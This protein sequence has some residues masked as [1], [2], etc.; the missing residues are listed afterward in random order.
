MRRAS[1]ATG[2]VTAL[3]CL[4]RRQRGL[5]SRHCRQATP[6]LAASTLQAGRIAGVRRACVWLWRDAGL[7]AR[8]ACLKRAACMAL[9][10]SRHDA[11]RRPGCA[12]MGTGGQ[13][14]AGRTI[15]AADTPVEVAGGHA[16]VAISAGGQHTCAIEALPSGKAFCWGVSQR[17]GAGWPGWAGWWVFVCLCVYLSCCCCSWWTP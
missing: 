7:C 8:D 6:T 2:G 17:S 11:P 14:G 3:M 15:T 10:F 16:F 9:G 5:H 12:G 4:C 13:L 1:W